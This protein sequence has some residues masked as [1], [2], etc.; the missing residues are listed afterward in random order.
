M[1]QPVILMI[2]VFFWAFIAL[3]LTACDD[4]L[5]VYQPQFSKTPKLSVTK[6]YVI[7]IHPLHNPSKLYEVFNPLAE[8]L[9][10]QIPTVKFRI[11]A[12]KDYACFNRKIE[13]E[14]LDF[15]LPNPYQTL[16][17]INK[18]YQVINQMG[19][20]DLFR[21]IILVRKDQNIKDIKQLKNKSIAYPAPTALAATMMPQYYLQTHGLNVKNNTQTYYVGSQE[22][23]ILNV[24]TQK[25][26]AAATWTVPWLELQKK[27]SEIANELEVLVQT[28]SLPNN[29]FMYHTLK[30]NPNLALRVQTL[31]S[32]LHNTPEGQ[33]LLESMNLTEV[34]N[35]TN[36]TY[37]PVTDFLNHFKLTVG[38]N[39]LFDQE[40]R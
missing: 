29:S 21:G 11:E 31:L 14:S 18:N 4:K 17:A 16:N 22:S 27:Q 33:A 5:P 13:Q 7:G 38:D 3:S 36:D 15:L 37:L 10:Q 2:K 30:V 1:R 12:S 35:A 32:N 39:T 24:Y 28:D 6:T 34:Y 25:T 23:S 26:L 9:S 19:S 8:Y 20:D 40:I